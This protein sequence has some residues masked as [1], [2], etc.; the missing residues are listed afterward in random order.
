MENTQ[1]VPG[2]GFFFSPCSCCLSLTFENKE[3]GPALQ[4][5]ESVE[6]KT[7][8]CRFICL[9]LQAHPVTASP[10]ASHS[11]PSQEN[12]K[13]V[14]IFSEPPA[15]VRFFCLRTL[16]G[17]ELLGVLV[18]KINTIAEQGGW[19]RQS[20]ARWVLLALCRV[21]EAGHELLPLV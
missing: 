12:P 9:F 18:F 8:Q 4:P 1:R 15:N 2:T 10:N 17:L 7:I 13:W 3:T 5:L 16:R 11:F 6:D 19:V 14:N 21:A 20:G